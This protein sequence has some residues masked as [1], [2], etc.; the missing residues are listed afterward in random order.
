M[1]WRLVA[2]FLNSTPRPHEI[3]EDQK[4]ANAKTNKQQPKWVAGAFFQSCDTGKGA[5]VIGILDDLQTKCGQ[6]TRNN[7]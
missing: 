1:V 3:D 7:K 4:Q 6:K 5:F 2:D